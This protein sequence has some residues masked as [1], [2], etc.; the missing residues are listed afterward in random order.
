M[1]Q[2]D[3]KTLENRFHAYTAPFVAE[4]LD[5]EPYKLKQIHTNRV[6]DNISMLP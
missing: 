2:D 1:T 3:L 6:C 4:A 5:P